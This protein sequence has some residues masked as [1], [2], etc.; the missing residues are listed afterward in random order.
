MLPFELKN[1]VLCKSRVS[2][3][4]C[5][6][7]SDFLYLYHTEVMVELLFP[8]IFPINNLFQLFS[9][10]LYGIIAI[11]L[12]FCIILPLCVLKQFLLLSISIPI[13]FIFCTT[14][15]GVYVV[16]LDKI[17]SHSSSLSLFQGHNLYIFE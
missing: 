3:H 5:Y 12:V 14:Y 17:A 9:I 10:A 13:Y 7:L 6:R 8:N 2:Y 4:H 11:F 1:I 16:L 15:I